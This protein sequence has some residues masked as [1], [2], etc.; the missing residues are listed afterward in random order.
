MLL[1]EDRALQGKKKASR[2]SPCT[3]VGGGGAATQKGIAFQNRAA[4]WVAVRILAEQ[5]A[6]PP[7]NLPGR[8]TFEF[9]RCETEQPVDDLLIGT[10]EGGFVFVQVKHRLTLERRHDSAFASAIDQFV[11]QFA[12]C[13]NGAAGRL[14]ER[15]L[16]PDRD[17]LVLL[18]GPNSSAAIREHLPS[19]LAKLPP[20]ASGPVI[21]V[22]AITQ[23]ERRALGVFRE[24]F[25][26]SWQR[27]LDNHRSDN[28]LVRLI[29]LIRVF[30][31]DVDEG[32]AAERE[33]KDRL[34][35]DVLCDATQADMAWNTLV[36]ACAGFASNRTGAD[37]DILQ[38]VLLDA[39]IYLRVPRSYYADIERLREYSR[40][41]V[42][43]L[44]D[45]SRT[46]VGPTEVKI[47]R[48]STQ[49]LR[50]A[51]EK[52]SLVVVGEPGAG[53]S[54]ALHDLVV[55]L[56]DEGRDFVFLAV[57][58]LEVQS[59]GALRNDIGLSHELLD[60]LANWHG[61]QPAFLV[62]DALDAARAD[63]SAQTVLDLIWQTAKVANRW[64]TV[65][66]IRKFDLRYSEKIGQLFSGAP[67]TQFQDTEFARLCHIN[68][69][70][71]DDEELDQIRV[72][73]RELADLVGAAGHALREMLRVP[74]N[75]RLMGDLL[76]EGIAM[77]E[78]TP[79][80]TQI[81]LLERY[82]LHRVIRNDRH[83]GAREE[84]LRRVTSEMV[85][86]RTLRVDRACI[87]K[88]IATSPILE[89]I[90]SSNILLE[91]QPSPAAKPDR[92]VLTFAHHVLFDYAVARLLLRGDPK[93]PVDL[94]AG[95]PELVLAIQPSLV[96]HFQYLWLS[97]A[98]RSD[99]WKCVLRLTRAEGIPEIGKLIGPGVAAE[100]ASDLAD[101]GA[102][103]SAL[104]GPNTATRDAAD[105]ALGHVIGA[106]LAAP[107]DSGRPL[108]GKGAGP[109]CE[110]LECISW[111]MRPPIAYTVR[112]LLCS[113]G[114]RP[115][116]LTSD[117]ES[118]AGVA[119]RRL[120][121]F[122]W[123]QA[124]R[125]SWLVI[126]AV[127]AVCRTF[128]SAPSAS[129]T[130]VRRC[131]EPTHLE[132]YGPEEMQWLA[133]EVG[134]LI[135]LDPKVVEDIYR[136]TFTHYEFSDA[137]TPIGA[138]RILP[139]T[140]TRGQDYRTAL[141]ELA[142]TYPSF[143]SL[144]PVHA[145]RALIIAVGAYVA[146][147]HP[148]ASGEV[149]E[150]TFDFAGRQ[151]RIRTDYSFIWDAGDTSRHEDVLKMVDAFEAHLIGLAK[152]GEGGAER[153]EVLDLLIAQNRFAV[154]WKYLLI[155]GAQAPDTLGQEIRAL[156]WAM[157]ILTCPDTTNAVGSLLHAVFGRL[158][159]GDRIRVEK[160]ILSIPQSATRGSAEG[161]ERMRN[162]LLGC[163]ASDYLV[164]D[165]A[166]QL[167]TD[168]TAT[169]KVP[170][171][172][173]LFRL[174]GWT[175]KP[176]SSEEYLAESGVP[177]D[178]QPNQR[179]RALEEPIEE[180]ARKHQK[181]LPM[182]DEIRAMLPALCSLRDALLT[183]GADG[184][185]Q[186]QSEH[187]W[188]CLA[189][190]CEQIAAYE[191]LTCQ[192]ELGTFIRSVLLEAAKH[193][194]P[195]PNPE[196]D[197]RFDEFPSWGSPAARIE[198]AGGLTWLASHPT[199]MDEM[200]LGTIERLRKDPVPAV[201]FQVG[202]RLLIL[203]RAAPNLMWGILE[204]SCNEETSRGVLQGLLS[205]VLGRLAGSHAN[206]VTNLTKAIYDRVTDGPGAKSVRKAC[207]SIFLGLY[208]RQDNPVCR[209]IVFGIASAPGDSGD[210][211]QRI[212]HN[213]R[214]FLACGPVS[215]PDPA[216]DEVR[217]RA[218]HLA[219]KMLRSTGSALRELETDH[220]EISFESWTRADQEHARTLARLAESI[221]MELYFASGAYDAKT[222]GRVLGIDEKRRFLQEATPLL[223]Q[224]AGFGFPSLVHH[225]LKTLEFLVPVDPAGVFLRIGHVVRAGQTG[226]Y[227]YE[228]LAVDLIVGLVERYLAEYRAVFRENEECQRTLLEILD[229]FVKVGWPSARR[230]TYRLQEIFR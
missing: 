154:L 193:A 141:W 202:T 213:L 196:Y 80:K 2:R 64:R 144:A 215:G 51:A 132:K 121:E 19:A 222:H 138:S 15:P 168:L 152:D 180:F 4:A 58:R 221:G 164:T 103:F 67:P 131:L 44:S 134:R 128:E 176:Y 189:Q 200:V 167:L 146:R 194:N 124:P 34:R 99:F 181:S 104:E 135:P 201:R 7:W 136:A 83:G 106:L 9:I 45:L 195:L 28:D 133:R 172:E 18:I 198:A 130:L 94:L 57:D 73:S 143:I 160:A 225:L 174:S 24:H 137:K 40:N 78:L 127:Q 155:C 46:R 29:S 209:D 26:R 8:T 192:N 125:D 86:A 156:A 199:C 1:L 169:D 197:A 166:K 102:L 85:Q 204:R 96:M 111:M 219:E 116:T 211:A 112:L 115:E 109:W 159:R 117:Q 12:A 147:R 16:N 81:E 63:R 52:D 184:V 72:Q 114:E 101:F 161:K 36:Q 177:V 11:R 157:P 170:P 62:I 92:Y 149:V 162:R 61:I 165:E 105:Q 70:G 97:D 74:F 41:T 175:S 13:R 129:G 151:A 60:I 218:F 183:A 20:V 212:V 108:V 30:T 207:T 76:G 171:N 42:A 14:W 59:L 153:R 122:A 120:L 27:A 87:D 5:A 38:R 186:Q 53:K 35:S 182:A 21:D 107:P 65:V 49:A 206:R 71:L 126:H 229:M 55:A 10:S 142:E 139:M 214:P 210:E 89:D 188:D 158:D 3:S 140:S 50:S 223:D 217:K 228:S 66:S 220:K 119:A 90:L 43:L 224:L 163:L 75:L 48:R 100:L 98:A 95:D 226:G 33:A 203:Y 47:T 145:V 22:A 69:R 191:G 88:D 118:G 91:W 216:Q 205:G 123:E 82:W 185:H 32:G 110:L 79:I 77:E 68:I 25:A 150:E 208:L 227:Q 84:V 113:I 39:G 56:H 190:A 23:E 17:R 179:I 230:L 148:P 173:P 6:S 37:R 54:G 31:L 178:A 93:I 187:A